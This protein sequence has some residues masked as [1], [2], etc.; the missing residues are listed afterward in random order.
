NVVSRVAL[1]A[2]AN[3]RLVLAEITQTRTC[4]AG[5]QHARGWNRQLVAD[6]VGLPR[7]LVIAEEEQFVLHDGTANRAAELVPLRRGDHTP[8]Y[9][10]GR[11][12]REGIAG[13]GG[14]RAPKPEAA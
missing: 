9:R 11:V 13:G 5:A 4:Q 7:A 8:G 3:E 12:L 2:V 6:A 10:I 14:I 1:C